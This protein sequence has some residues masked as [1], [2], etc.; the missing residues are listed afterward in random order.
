MNRKDK[1][2]ALISRFLE[3]RNNGLLHSAS[4]E[5]IRM[6][7]NDMLEVVGWDVNNTRQVM[8]ER[9]LERSERK[10]LHDIS[11]RYIKPDY[12]MMNGTTRLFFIDA[13]KQAVDIKNDKNVA[14]QIRSYGC[15]IS[16][17]Q[18]LDAAMVRSFLV[19]N[20]LAPG[21]GFIADFLTNFE[22]SQSFDDIET[23]E[24]VISIFEQTVPA[25]EKT[26]N[27]AIYT[28]AY[29]REFIVNH[30]YSEDANRFRNGLIIDPACGCGAFLYTAALVNKNSTNTFQSVLSRLYGVD[31]S[32]N[33]VRRTKLILA[34]TALSNGEC[35]EESD[36]HIH[37]ANALSFDFNQFEAVATA[38]GYDFVIGNP[39]YVRSKHIEA[40]SKALLP[41]WEVAIGGNA[42]LYLPFFEIGIKILNKNGKL[43]YITLNSFFK[44]VNARGL[45]NYFSKNQI[46]LD[47]LDFGDELI[48]SKKL[49]YTCITF[50]SKQERDT[51]KYHRS[52]ADEIRNCEDIEYD[53]ISYF[54]LDNHKGWNL[55]QNDILQI[56]SR[57]EHTGT[58]LG[59]KYRI[60]NGIATLANALFIFQPNREDESY[61][62]LN[63]N[64]IEFCIEKGICR[65]IIKPNILHN[66]DEIE[67]IM[68]KVI[69]P[70]DSNYKPI[71][72]AVF[73]SKY[74]KAYQYL[75]L[76]RRKLDER[77]KGEGNFPVWYAFG[78]TQAI[79]DKGKKL[80]FPYMTD[81]PHFVFTDNEDML[82]Y[83]GYAIFHDDEKELKILK[84]LLESSVFDYYMKHTSK[85]YA[86]GYYSYAKNYVKNFGIYPLTPKQKEELL[87]LSSKEEID[88][89][90]E[91]LYGIDIKG[92]RCYKRPQYN[93]IPQ[94]IFEMV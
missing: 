71:P 37:C 20:G 4:E 35:I 65:D 93:Y 77:D 63:A 27:G 90:V 17:P 36:L 82:I 76:H 45:R 47:I 9:T 16:D 34:L 21:D 59:T 64:N 23:I 88:E 3:A 28:P 73:I 87:C 25:N 55:N 26:K 61:Y 29:I 7:I 11:S 44:S 51:I 39:P 30:L 80:L 15:H 72:E 43:G 66:E 69:F 18:Q 46:S 33:S 89:Y 58:P 31:I 57:I 79:S 94:S 74:P 14:F 2:S 49:A 5:T 10:R 6:W 13:K 68:E 12:T 56:I 41:N 54:G 52:S 85:P 92:N 32:P 40:E 24:D 75:S 38:G 48:F 42:D 78:R 50:I 1:F 86:T 8:Q 62:Y 70:Y 81:V 22:L 83:C 60:K 67:S 84:R 91:R 19:N 53:T